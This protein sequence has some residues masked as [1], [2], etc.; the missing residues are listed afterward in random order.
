M[1]DD[2]GNGIQS[3]LFKVDFQDSRSGLGTTDEYGY[4]Q[5]YLLCKNGDQIEVIPE[6]GNYFQ[7]TIDCTKSRTINVELGKKR[8]YKLIFIN[9]NE[10]VAE[11]VAMDHEKIKIDP[12]DGL[13]TVTIFFRDLDQIITVKNLKTTGKI[14]SRVVTGAGIGA[15]IGALFFGIGAIPGAIIGSIFGGTTSTTVIGDGKDVLP[16]YYAPKAN[17]KKELNY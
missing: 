1:S 16:I 9:G 13:P 14:G 3:E 15:G 8:L 4:K 2:K 5:I 6:S 10:I 12:V 17:L 7:R 11:I